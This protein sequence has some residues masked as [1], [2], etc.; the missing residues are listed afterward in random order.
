MAFTQEGLFGK[1]SG[2]IG[3]LVVFQRNGQ[4][5]VRSRTTK[6]IPAATGAKKQAQQNFARV[7]KLM[8]VLKPFIT[9]GFGDVAGD[10]SAFHTALSVNLQRLREAPEPA[11]LNWLL[12]SSGSRA[13]ARQINLEVS[14]QIAAISWGEPT[15]A[16]PFAD[17]DQVMIVAINSTTLEVTTPATLIARSQKQASLSLPPASTG[18]QVYLFISFYDPFAIQKNTK[19][20]SEGEIAGVWMK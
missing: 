3:N 20:V 11:T 5:V 16:K 17:H 15:P 19:N 1:F 4:T 9:K 7:M 18:E 10:R 13:G 6:K 8:Q 2:R 12:T 14:D